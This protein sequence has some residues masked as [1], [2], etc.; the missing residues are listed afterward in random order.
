MNCA[1]KC[2]NCLSM[3][4]RIQLGRNMESPCES[5]TLRE[6]EIELKTK[7]DCALL[8]FLVKWKLII[9]LFV[10]CTEYYVHSWVAEALLLCWW[11]DL[12][13]T[14]KTYQNNGGSCIGSGTGC[15]TKMGRWQ[16]WGGGGGGRGWWRGGVRMGFHLFPLTTPVL[17]SLK[18]RLMLT[19]VR[20][21]ALWQ[22]ILLNVK[23]NIKC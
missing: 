16:W 2:L 4:R 20:P 9:A 21:N 14:K 22:L 17:C 11:N 6:A 18:K 7:L 13:G 1:V 5:S 23:I 12:Q 19:L 10:F 3:K 8:S 15:L